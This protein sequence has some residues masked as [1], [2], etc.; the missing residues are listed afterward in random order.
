MPAAM[1]NE[2]AEVTLCVCNFIASLTI[3]CGAASQ[4]KRQPVMAYALLKPLIVIVRSAMP[5]SAARE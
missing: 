1:L 2:A 3:G 5:G 4:P